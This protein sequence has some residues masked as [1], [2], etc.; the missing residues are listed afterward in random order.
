MRKIVLIILACIVPLSLF[1]QQKKETIAVMTLKGS[2]GI[3]KDEADLLS[4]RLRVEFFK[5]GHVDVMER[6]QMSEVLKEQGFQ[7]SGACTN[8]QCMIE[9]GQILGVQ[10]LITGSIGKVGSLFLLNLRVIDIK[11]AKITKSVSEDVKGD[12]EEVVKLLSKIAQEL[13]EVEQ[14]GEMAVQ[15]E[16]TQA[17]PGP[18]KEEAPA[19]PSQP[20]ELNC[21]GRAFI[22]IIPFPKSSLGFDMLDS[23]W[24]DAYK[25][26]SEKIADFLKSGVEAAEKVSID[27]LQNCNAFIIRPQLDSY[28]TR[29]ARM[30]QK[31]GMIR[32]TFL[33]FEN[34][35]AAEAKYQVTVDAIGERNWKDVKPFIFACSEAAKNLEK[36][37]DK[38]GALSQLNA[39]KK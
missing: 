7:Q 32:M 13:L 3:T 29:P 21:D 1:G 39:K 20:N 9:M 6:E 34:S 19:G 15:R 12:L 4:D 37:L 33:F 38:N 14:V 35:T 23:D 8:D 10:K 22:E 17:P 25:E 18:E 27:K 26:M 36:G 5:T 24:K 11:T 28:S 16:T 31:E 30:G 2:S